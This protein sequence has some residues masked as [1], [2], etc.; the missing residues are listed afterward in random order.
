MCKRLAG[1]ALPP[2]S[3]AGSW[4]G[5]KARFVFPVR[6]WVDWGRVCAGYILKSTCGPGGPFRI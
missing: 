1:V 5:E 4:V 3:Q 2:G 6:A